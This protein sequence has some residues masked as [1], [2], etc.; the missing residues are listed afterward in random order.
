MLEGSYRLSSSELSADESK[1]GRVAEV[2]F[3]L[4]QRMIILLVSMIFQ[5][6]FLVPGG[7]S[8]PPAGQTAKQQG[9]R[10]ARSDLKMSNVPSIPSLLTNL[11]ISLCNTAP[12]DICGVSMTHSKCK[13][14]C[15]C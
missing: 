12:W 7:H 13:L 8:A 3:L 14:K 6:L 4:K 2:V 1:M 9:L 15:I 11:H 5:T 10:T